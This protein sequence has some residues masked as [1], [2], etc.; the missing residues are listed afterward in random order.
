MNYY[1]FLYSGPLF[2]S[3][4]S[5]GGIMLETYLQVKKKTYKV[6]TYNNQIEYLQ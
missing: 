1:L 5:L 6:K 3:G 4:H 2:I